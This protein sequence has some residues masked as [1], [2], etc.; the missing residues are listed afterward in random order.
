MT[1][2]AQHI[3]E[4]IVQTSAVVSVRLYRRYREI[5]IAEQ[6]DLQQELWLWARK[7]LNKIEQW[8]DPEQEEADYQRGLHA[9]E[10]SMYRAGDRYCRSM[11]AKRAGYSVR[12]EVFYSTAYIETLLPD[13]WN[14]VHDPS[15]VIADS[16]KAPSNPAEGGNRAVTMFD[17]RYAVSKLDR[18][19]RQLVEWRFR[20]GLDIHEIAA[21]LECSKTTVYRNLRRVMRT[22]LDTLGG[23]SPW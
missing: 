16:P 13:A 20:D 8:L 21:L 17:V 2:V 6:G 7:R 14:P 23:P 5:L 10:K 12:D 11:K 15:V 22:L 3:E 19:D 4:A 9:L 1:S 18:H